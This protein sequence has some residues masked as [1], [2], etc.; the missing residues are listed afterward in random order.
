LD[1]IWTVERGDYTYHLRGR[2]SI[3]SMPRGFVTSVASTTERDAA[4]SHV[5]VPTG[6]YSLTL[7]TGYTLERLPARSSE[8]APETTAG[9]FVKTLPALL[10]SPNPLI[11]EA[12][13][14]R[15][16]PI[17]LSLVDLSGVAGEDAPPCMDRS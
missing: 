10:V 8:G 7:D 11:V 12:K 4:V 6:L 14:G 17:G 15:I 16:A 2:Y 3:A 5:Y 1:F 9:E 13:E